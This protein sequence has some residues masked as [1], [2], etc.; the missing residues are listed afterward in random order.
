FRFAHLSAGLAI[1]IELKTAIDNSLGPGAAVSATIA[2]IRLSSGE[3][4]PAGTLVTGQLSPSSS[5]T[6]QLVRFDTLHLSDGTT[7]PIAARIID[8]RT[9][10]KNK[11]AL[12]G[13]GLLLTPDTKLRAG[14]KL[15]IKLEAPA[16]VAVNGS[17]L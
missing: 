12:A 11:V 14:S 7:F 2:S 13:G 4:L 10:R 8:G 17:M 9:L 3:I 5:G 1:P 16:Q 6:R 15:T